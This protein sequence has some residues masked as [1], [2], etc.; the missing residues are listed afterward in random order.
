MGFWGA[1]GNG[2]KSMAER[3]ERQRQ[4]NEER[5]MRYSGYD[6]ERLIKICKNKDKGFFGGP[7]YDNRQKKTAY[8]ILKKRGY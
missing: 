5:Y 3:A 7:L 6:D 8:D 2:I 1:V 4:E